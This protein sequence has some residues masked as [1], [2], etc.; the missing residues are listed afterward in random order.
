MLYRINAFIDDESGE[1]MASSKE[2]VD[3]TMDA[4]NLATGGNVSSRAMMGEHVVYY[5]DKVIGGIYNDRLLIKVT[6]SS[7]AAIPEDELEL[8][9]EGAKLMLRVRNLDDLGFI[10]GLFE[11]MY[12]ELPARKAK[13][14]K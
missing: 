7:S 8:P 12:D 11:A 6:P 9:Y 4:L 1:T 3:S 2:F 10:A 13:S 14:K 5:R